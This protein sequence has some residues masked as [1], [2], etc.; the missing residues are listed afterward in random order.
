MVIVQLHTVK[1]LTPE[2][3]EGLIGICG[4]YLKSIGAAIESERKTT[5]TLSVVDT[6]K[7]VAN[8]CE[9]KVKVDRGDVAAKMILKKMPSAKEFLVSE[10]V[11]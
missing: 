11:N 7:A 1:N 6:C 4:A 9:R 8:N 10:A 2:Q 3:S 5:P